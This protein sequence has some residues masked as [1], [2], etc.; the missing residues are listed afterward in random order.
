[1]LKSIS[2]DGDA[3]ADFALVLTVVLTVVDS[4]ALAASDFNL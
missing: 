2:I 3:V 1:M 4:H